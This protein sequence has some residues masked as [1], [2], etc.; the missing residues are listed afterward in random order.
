MVRCSESYFKAG[1]RFRFGSEYF[2]L[3]TD[4]VGSLRDRKFEWSKL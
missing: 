3:K 4:S 2:G 1:F